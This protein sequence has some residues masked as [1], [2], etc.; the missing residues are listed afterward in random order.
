MHNMQKICT[1]CTICKKYA[2]NAFWAKYAKNTKKY[3]KNMPKIC[4]FGRVYILHKTLLMGLF[5]AG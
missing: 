4:S 5:W 2:Q 1:I 3:S